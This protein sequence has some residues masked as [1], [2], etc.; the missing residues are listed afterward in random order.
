LAYDEEE[1]DLTWDDYPESYFKIIRGKYCVVVAI[2]RKIRKLF[3]NSPL[4]Q[5][6][7]GSTEA[8]FHRRRRSLTHKIYQEF[9]ERQA[10]AAKDREKF[11]NL[12]KTEHLNFEISIE[13]GNGEVL[14]NMISIFD[15]AVLPR[16]SSYSFFAQIDE[17]NY[18]HFRGNSH[19]KPLTEIIPYQ[20][21]LQLKTQMD[22][23]AHMVWSDQKRF[24]DIEIRTAQS[25]LQPSVRS[26]FEDLLVEAA[27]KQK[28]S[29]PS[30]L[31][32]LWEI[33]GL[34]IM[35]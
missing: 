23:I 33:S 26:Y 12:L 29:I 31:M 24:T 30:F 22:A 27:K 4:R 11:K 16:G 20:E 17:N 32:L 35:T 34:K 9:D 19:V 28:F 7:A 15:K 13:S 6:V 8:D 5:K 1:D 10:N 14:Q 21:L 2:P 3:G 18:S 25:Y